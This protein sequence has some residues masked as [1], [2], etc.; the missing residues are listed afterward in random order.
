MS[1]V[2]FLSQML[3]HAHTHRLYRVITMMYLY[4]VPPWGGDKAPVCLSWHR[5]ACENRLA[6]RGHVIKW[7][8][9]VH[10]RAQAS[11]VLI[12]FCLSPPRA[13]WTAAAAVG[14]RPEGLHRLQQR[15]VRKLWYLPFLSST[16]LNIRKG[17]KKHSQLVLKEYWNRTEW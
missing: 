4:D 16:K 1:F 6:R 10:I 17:K 3:T 15:K 2:V 11:A 5:R 12:L 14:E 7:S 9:T 13:E 8:H